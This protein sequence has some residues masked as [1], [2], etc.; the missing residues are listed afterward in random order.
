MHAPYKGITGSGE[1]YSAL[2][3]EPW[4]WTVCATFDS[5][6]YY[7]RNFSGRRLTAFEEDELYQEWCIVVAHLGIPRSQMPRRIDSFE[8]YVSH[9][10]STRLMTNEAVRGLL[11]KFEFSDVASPNGI[12]RAFWPVGK[13]ILR[14]LVS[15]GAMGTLPPTLRDKLGISWSRRDEKWLTFLKI[16]ARVLH[17]VI[18]S[19]IM[20]DRIA[21]L[22]MQ[23]A[24]AMRC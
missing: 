23:E 7:H 6:L 19:I 3:L 14:R 22:A 18:P 4:M 20:H 16:C 24:R 5:I 21:Y 1:K 8:E 11:R 12:P 13:L 10:V 2:D 15:I 17:V 9:M